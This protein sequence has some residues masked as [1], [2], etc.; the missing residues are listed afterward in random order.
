MERPSRSELGKILRLEDRLGYE[1]SHV[2]L[3]YTALHSHVGVRAMQV[4]GDYE[5]K[6]I[7]ASIVYR[8]HEA[9]HNDRH[10]LQDVVSQLVSNRILG[11]V[12]VERGIATLAHIPEGTFKEMA[13][14]AK[15]FY[16]VCA[17]VLEAVAYA[18]RVDAIA[19]HRYHLVEHMVER[20][21]GGE[22]VRAI[23]HRSLNGLSDLITRAEKELGLQIHRQ[24]TRGEY[25]VSISYAWSHDDRRMKRKRRHFRDSDV[26]AIDR[27]LFSLIT[28]LLDQNMFYTKHPY[29]LKRL[30][31]G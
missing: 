10:G 27:K 8:R 2:A 1:F 29:T 31:G 19:T 4:A 15:R 16:E 14:S 12:C 20:L 11:S 28:S 9:V 13:H 5:L 25:R 21:M 7:I 3:A 26:R 17:D 18:V 30:Q 22:I 24:R 6:A 23:E